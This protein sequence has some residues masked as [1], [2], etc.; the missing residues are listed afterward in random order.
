[1]VQ[2]LIIFFCFI[3]SETIEQ[4]IWFSA[5]FYLESIL[6]N[7]LEEF[8]QEEFFCFKLFW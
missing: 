7:F 4:N 6:P 8:L 5:R 1:M 3:T 2:K